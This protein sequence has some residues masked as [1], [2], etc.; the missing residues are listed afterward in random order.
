VGEREESERR[1]RVQRG[2]TPSVVPD[3]PLPVPDP[4]DIRI[5]WR[6]P[7]VSLGVEKGLETHIVDFPPVGAEYGLHQ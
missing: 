4:V 1:W 2:W 6:L 7:R 5:R 3:R